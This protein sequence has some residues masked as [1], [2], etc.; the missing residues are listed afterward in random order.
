MAT[1]RVGDRDPATGSVTG[2]ATAGTAAAGELARGSLSPGHIVFMVIAA[3]APMAVIVAIAPLAFVLGNGAGTPGMFLLFALLLAV[4]AVGYT[5]AVPYVRNAGAFYAY[6]TQGLGRPIGLV[7]AYAAMVCYTSLAAATCGA[8]AFF[9]DDTADRLLGI[10][11]GWEI[12]AAIG[13]A[14]VLVFGYRRITL[15]ARVLAVALTLEV[16]SLLVLDL[17]ILGDQGPGAFP[18]S[19]FSPDV[20][21]SGVV[22]VAII[23]AFS[24]FMGFE[25][26]A[27]YA[28][29]A[30]DPKRTIPRATYAA[31]AIVGIFY[32]L[33]TWALIAGVGADEVVSVAG[34]D[35]GGFVFALSDTY[36]G[37]AWT[38]VL[39]VLIVTSS[40]AAVLA[41][42]NA[43]ARYFY[44]LSR[45]GF[46]PAPL[47][48]THPRFAS[49]HV[50]S[51]VQWTLLV[52]IV[53]G[54]AI[55]GLDPL[56][57][58]STAMTG[59][60]AVGLMAML[61]VTSLAILAFFWKRGERGWA[62]TVAPIVATA[63]LAV[64]TV[65]ALVN[66]PSLTGSTS[67]VINNLPWLHLITIA[68]GIG[69]ALR[70]RARKPAVYAAMGSTRVEG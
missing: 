1:T 68:L 17:A 8:L 59:F 27:I 23:Y 57:N 4:F 24:S 30:R 60:G 58:L 18:A 16:I 39:T 32:V 67:S 40:F 5:R 64:S 25:G 19:S 69:I 13:L 54:F 21:F 42:H 43:A 61:A 10:D 14:L 7:A 49:P 29:E 35:P 22:G 12:W 62:V 6:I 45:D 37:G 34:A 3:A 53:A 55:A 38:D 56:T 41:F 2:E 48:R 65:L 33:T 15:A 51:L 26:T 52:A 36:V 66:Y 28:E 31:V 70:M 20:V 50:A 63:G 11:L 47:G 9:A 44:A 46:L